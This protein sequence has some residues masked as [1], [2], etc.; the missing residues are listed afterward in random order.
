MK[1]AVGIDIGGTKTAIAAVTSEGRIVSELS[2]PTNSAAGF[3]DGTERIV[4]SVHTVVTRAGW[5][6]EDLAGIGIGCAGPVDPV[7]GSIHN[8]YTLPGWEDAH[9]VRA[10]AEHL[11]VPVWLENDAD[12]ALLGE[13]CFGAGQGCDPVV[14]LTF[15][16]GVGGGILAQG[17]IVRGARGQHPE[18]GHLSVVTNGAECYCGTRGCL[19]SIASGTAIGARGE[20]AGWIDARAVFAAARAG[21]TSA[22]AIVADAVNAVC[23]AVWTIAHTVLPQRLLLGGGIMDEHYD[24][25][26]GSATAAL[27]RAT[28]FDPKSVTVAKAALGNRAG[29][30]GAASLALRAG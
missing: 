26:A 9:I 14:M 18:L 17:R 7:Q 11:G 5:P 1:K 22:A 27:A 25:F 10:L 8:P 12:A 15:G 21:E 13:C 24:L 23:T 19:E 20:A 3:A 29:L 2:L 6:C 4:R 28:Q 30:A 16:T